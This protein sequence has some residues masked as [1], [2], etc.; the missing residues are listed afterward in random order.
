LQDGTLTRSNIDFEAMRE[1][2]GIP[3]GDLFTVMES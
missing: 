3:V 2:C 1:R